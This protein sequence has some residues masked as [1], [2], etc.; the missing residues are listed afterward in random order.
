VILDAKYRDLWENPLL[1]DTLCQ[2]AMYTLSQDVGGNAAILYSTLDDTAREA[3]IGIKDLIYGS[4]RAQVI[5]RPV[6]LFRLERLITAPNNR[7]SDRDKAALARQL[8]FGQ[9]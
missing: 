5:L 1:R 9:T 3:R 6:N 7:Q 2:L 8:V 4:N